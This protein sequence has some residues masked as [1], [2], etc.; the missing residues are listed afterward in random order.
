MGRLTLLLGL[1]LGCSA[2]VNPPIVSPGND[3]PPPSGGPPG[4]DGGT[5]A[6]DG[7]V[8][9]VLASGLATPRGIAATGGY[10]YVTVPSGADDAGTSGGILRIP[11]TGGTI[12]SFIS[13]IDGPLGLA[14]SSSALCFTTSPSAGSGSVECAPL[15][16]GAVVMLVQ[17]ETGL[18]RVVIDNGTAYWASL[19][20][21]ALV[22]KAPVGGGGASTVTTASGAFAPSGIAVDTGILYVTV[23]QPGTVYKVPTSGGAAEALTDPASASYTDTVVDGA[24]VLVGGPGEILA[25]PTAGG[26]S[27]VVVSGLTADPGH[28]A[29]DPS[30]LYWTSPGDGQVYALSLTSGAVPVSIASG[31]NSPNAIAV[32]DAVYV[33]T[34]DGVVRVARAL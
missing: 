19:Q 1:L 16:G 11:E 13:G 10:V 29:R 5:S 33:T 3:T 9:T 28:L 2:P 24:R 22:E 23:T 15:F 17:G 30:H 25:F 21:G 32:D 26:A 7:G 12:T 18:S 20:A 14:A 34:L 4:N 27:S 6:G 31:L 8:L